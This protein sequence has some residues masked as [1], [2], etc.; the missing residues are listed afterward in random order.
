MKGEVFADRVPRCEA[1]KG[2]EEGE[3][4]TCQ[5]LVKPDIIFFGEPLPRRFFDLA[6]E[7][8]P[9]GDL[10]IVMGTSLAVQVI[11]SFIFSCL[12]SFFIDLSSPL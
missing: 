10:L 4:G 7:D 11:F 1:K 3:E 5:G 6:E 12:F 8:F 9:Q 2:E